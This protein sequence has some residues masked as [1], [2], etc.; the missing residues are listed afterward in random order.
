VQK[1]VEFLDRVKAEYLLDS[2]YQLAHKLDIS[3]QAISKFRTGRHFFG[4]VAAVKVA[5]LLDL[6]PMYVLAC[7]HLERSIFKNDS[8]DAKFWQRYVDRFS[9]CDSVA[10]TQYSLLFD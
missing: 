5:E 8:D 1:T 4:N 2:D 9:S 7:S 6:L 10:Q 3:K